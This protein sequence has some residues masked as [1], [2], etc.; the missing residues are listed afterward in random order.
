MSKRKGSS[1]G[2]DKKKRKTE[3]AKM[4]TTREDKTESHAPSKIDFA[5]SQKVLESLISSKTVLKEFFAEYWE[6]KPL[7]VKR[8]DV[9]YYGEMFTK[10]NLVSILKKHNILYEDDINVCRFV[11]GEKEILNKSGRATAKRIQEDVEK[12][13]A[14]VQFHQPQRFKVSKLTTLR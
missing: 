7:H 2:N 12:L 9:E 1:S 6:K 8:E 14:T 11:D 4:K 3:K 10:E 13:K 5:S